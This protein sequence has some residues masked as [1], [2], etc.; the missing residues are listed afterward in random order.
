MIGA[1][2]LVWVLGRDGNISRIEGVMLFGT[3]IGYVGWTIR[4]SRREE[5]G[6]R[7]LYEQKYASRRDVSW[8]PVCRQVGLVFVGLV[9][10]TIGAKWLV[11][12]AS[13]IARLLGM[14]E[15]LIGLTIVAVGTSLPEAAASALASWRGE[16]D[17]AV[18]NIIGSN[19][20][21][22]LCVL[23]LSA[24]VSPQGVAVSAAALQLDIPVMIAVAIV[25]FPIFFTGQQI[26]RWEGGLFL[27]YYLIYTLYRVLFESHANIA[28]TFGTVL[29]AFLIPLT[30]IPL[31][32]SLLRA[33]YSPR[34]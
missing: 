12:G 3:L 10:L 14:G 32:I 18:G 25:C 24:A 23:G 16:R 17:I 31:L 4:Q 2:I 8:R 33:L 28:D 22:I 1:S 5:P 21:N 15:L 26:A 30:A 7:Q 34:D 19:L 13:T 11:D 20:F 27:A 9:M 6:T 29:L